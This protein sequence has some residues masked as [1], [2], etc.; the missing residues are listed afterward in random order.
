[1]VNFSKKNFRKTVP[2]FFVHG[3]RSLCR[4]LVALCHNSTRFAPECRAPGITKT[5]YRRELR[6]RDILHPGFFWPGKSM[7]WLFTIHIAIFYFLLYNILHCVIYFFTFYTFN[8]LIS[9]S[10]YVNVYFIIL[11]SNYINDGLQWLLHL[12]M[13]YNAMAILQRFACLFFY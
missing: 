10:F 12:P 8:I 2:W 13:L 7:W 1:M 9:N 6:L 4:L 11:I 3:L 5:T